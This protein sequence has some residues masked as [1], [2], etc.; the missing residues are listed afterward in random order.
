MLMTRYP[1]PSRY[2]Q[3]CE[4]MNPAP[5]ATTARA[6]FLNALRVLGSAP[7]FLLLYPGVFVI[8]PL[9]LSASCPYRPT[10]M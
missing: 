1:R 7:M 6:P 4:P 3:R 8:G 9:I 10:P 5:P 2:S